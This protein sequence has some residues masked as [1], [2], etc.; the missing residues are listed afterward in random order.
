MWHVNADKL[1]AD[2]LEESQA[3]LPHLI[4]QRMTL[5]L[6]RAVD[7]LLVRHRY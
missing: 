5:M 7:E 3:R 2:V 6:N 4:G 1:F